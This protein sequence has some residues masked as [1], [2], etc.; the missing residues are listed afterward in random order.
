VIALKATSQK[1]QVKAEKEREM[2]TSLRRQKE[3]S[4]PTL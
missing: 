1:T 3:P 4:P 2:D